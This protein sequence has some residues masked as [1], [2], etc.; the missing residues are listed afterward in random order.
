ME[1]AAVPGPEEL[2][3]DAQEFAD[4]EMGTAPNAVTLRSAA[5]GFAS[6]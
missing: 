5:A 6:A 3:T 1:P 2:Q 4:A